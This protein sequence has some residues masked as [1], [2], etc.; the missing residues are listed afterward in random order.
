MHL[1]N[2]IPKSITIYTLCSPTK[3]D[4][5]ARLPVCQ[6]VHFAC[7]GPSNSSELLQNQLVLEDWETDLLTVADITALNL[8]KAQLAYL[9]ACH[10]TSNQ[11]PGLL[12]EAVHLT[13]ACQLAGFPYV[14]GTLWR[15]DEEHSAGVAGDVYAMTKDGA[16]KVAL[17]SEALHKSVRRLRDRTRYVKGFSREIDDD[18]LIWAPYIHLGA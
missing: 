13:G 16:I 3:A 8:E 10:A 17:S 18:P 1:N 9:S 14:I 12:D 6:I 5:I 11:V 15:I 2:I 4:I 7:H